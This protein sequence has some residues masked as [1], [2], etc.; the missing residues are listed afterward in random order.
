MKKQFIFW[1]TALSVLA[2]AV[3]LFDRLHPNSLSSF[4]AE[5]V[6]INTIE[7][8]L[9]ELRNFS[10][11][12]RWFGTV[13]SRE[14][15]EIKPVTDGGIMAV[16]VKDGAHVKSNEPL[17]VLGGE[18]AG[19]EKE[20]LRTEVSSLENQVA[21]M[22]DV[23]RSRSYAASK[24]LTTQENLVAAK[25][26]LA[27]LQGQLATARQKLATLND[28]LLIRSPMDG[29]FTDR[30]VSQGQYV[31]RATPLADVIS[32]DLRITAR[33]FVPADTDLNGKIVIVHNAPGKD[34]EGKIS[35]VL[36][37]QTPDGATVVWIEGREISNSMKP[38]ESVS[39]WIVI[40]KYRALAVPE[41]AVLR[42]DKG[43]TFVVVKTDKGYRKVR[44]RT[45]SVQHGWCEIASGVGPSDK[46]ITRGAYEIFNRD[47]SSSY[48][49][50]D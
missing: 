2:G 8:T 4:D 39:G 28:S 19:H 34:A 14:R 37:A 21:L 47:F 29:I 35:T 5:S 18:T 36:P 33:V 10:V 41:D 23:V 42:D 38:G 26:R 31:T 11:R 32:D 40:R 15:V 25:A 3:L 50:I 27:A 17:F 49:L 48:R 20:I 45:R 16:R 44:V 6:K 46:V 1:V 12:L 9:P 22:K 43:K 24:K 7:T 13:E 30:L